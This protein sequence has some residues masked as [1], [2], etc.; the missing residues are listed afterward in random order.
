MLPAGYS[1]KAFGVLM[2]KRSNG[3][4]AFHDV[5]LHGNTFHGRGSASGVRHRRLVVAVWRVFLGRISDLDDV[6]VRSRSSSIEETMAFHIAA[7][8]TS[9]LAEREPIG[10]SVCGTGQRLFAAITVRFKDV[11]NP[12][13]P[14]LYY[15]RGPG[16][17]W[18]EKWGVT[19]RS[20]QG[21]T[22]RRD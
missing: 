1:Q 4:E 17:R 19:A 22:F 7:T 9:I 10:V 21:T 11:F 13:R 2:S 20:A 15:M 3:R 8:G 14:E 6:I 18:R 12:Y 16:P 5:A